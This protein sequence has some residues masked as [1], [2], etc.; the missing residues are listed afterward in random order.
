MRYFVRLVVGKDKMTFQGQ[1]VTWEE[2]PPLLEKVPDRH[3]TVFQ[4]ASNSGKD[5]I[6]DPDNDTSSLSAEF[7]ELTQRAMELCISFGFE[8]LS[9]VGVHPL[10][11]K[12]GPPKFVPH[13]K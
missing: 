13:N 9:I 2:L 7:E 11:T 6:Y 12:G 3:Y 4:I 5:F 8:Y 1:E 10:G